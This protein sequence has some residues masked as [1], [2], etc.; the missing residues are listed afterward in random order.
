VKIKYYTGL[1]LIALMANAC[2]KANPGHCFKNSGPVTTESRETSP[3][4]ILNLQDNVDVFLTYSA[5]YAIE[6]RAGKNII[7]G[8]KTNISGKT[9][10][11]SNE[12]HCNWVRSFDKPIEVYLSLPRIDSILYQSSGNLISTNQFQGD[13]LRLDVTDGAGSIRLNISMNRSRFNLHYGTADLEVE[14]YSHI[15]YL[16]SGGYGPAD[17]SRLNTVFNYMTNNSTNNCYVRS[18]L[19][20][21]VRIYNVGDV[22]YSGNPYDITTEISGTGKL[23]KQ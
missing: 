16:Y 13:S 2:E 18:D 20:L 3:F 9:L 21:H 8:I 14:G 6:V 19:V 4:T 1:I 11:I 15:N 5:E 10:T 17:L 22:Y 23:Y 7:P 12:N